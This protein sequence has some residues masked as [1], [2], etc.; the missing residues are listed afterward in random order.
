MLGAVLLAGSWFGWGRDGLTP[1]PAATTG[2]D[3]INELYLLM[4]GIAIVIF[5]SVVLPL[6]LN[7]GRYRARGLPREAE[8]PQIRGN[9]RLELTWTAIPVAIVLFIA[10]VTLWKATRIADPARA[11]GTDEAE[12]RIRVEGRQFYFR[13]V[14]PNG[15]I[16]IDHLR[17]PV[18]RVVRFEITAPDHDVIH[19]FWSPAIGGKMDAIPGIVN[20]LEV[21]ATKTGVFDGRCTELCGIQHGAMELAVEVMPQAAYDRWVERAAAAQRAGESELGETLFVGVCTK[22]HFAAPEYAPDIAGNPLLADAEGLT[23]V[24]RNGRGRMPAVGRGWTDREMNALLAYTRTLVPQQ[25]G[26]D[27]G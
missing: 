27:G 23:E 20:E 2:A 5:L 4:G 18:D 22:C 14:Y 8:G 9:T 21:R 11:A 12:L 25:E 19:S 15:A 10:G 17:I 6:A 24:V 13:Y 26:G 3:E 1:V 16:A 7:L